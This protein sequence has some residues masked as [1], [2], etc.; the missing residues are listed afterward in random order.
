MKRHR[1]A[2]KKR[3]PLTHLFLIILCAVVLLPVAFTLFYSLFPKSEIEQFLK[4]RNNYDLSVFMPVPFSP[5]LVS[6]RQYYT[7]LI[8]DQTYLHFFSNSVMYGFFI[9]IGQ[10]FFAPMMAYALSRFQFRGRNA[11]YFLILILMVLPFQV[12]M[13]PNVIALRTMG[14]LGSIWAIVLP[15]WFMPF[16]IFLIRQFMVAVPSELYEAGMMDGA[17]PWRLYWSVTLPVCKP[18]LSTAAVLSFADQWNMVEQPLAYLQ[19]RSMMPISVM[20]GQ[21]SEE[22]ASIVFAGAALC[23]LPMLFIYF[24]FQDDIISGLQLSE[25]K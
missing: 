22:K 20:F 10:A 3:Y 21:L 25:L 1:I 6:L 14:L 24:Y 18:V 19:D 9:L 16:Y 4:M 2:R 13:A 15:N 7:L 11:L 5:K 23:I 12:T 17:G 8:E